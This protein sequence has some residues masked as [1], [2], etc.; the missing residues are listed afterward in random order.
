MLVGNQM[1]QYLLTL[2]DHVTSCH[3]QSQ[4]KGALLLKQCPVPPTTA[5]S[6]QRTLRSGPAPTSTGVRR[7]G[8]HSTP[9]LGSGTWYSREAEDFRV[10][11]T[12]R[13]NPHLGILAPNQRCYEIS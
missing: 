7:A 13:S 1:Y 6:A 11:E 3:R 2:S 10:E 8:A 12:G 9:T 4:G 5:H